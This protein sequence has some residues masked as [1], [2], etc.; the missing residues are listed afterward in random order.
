MSQKRSAAWALA[1]LLGAAVLEIRTMASMRSALPGVKCDDYI[2]RI[3]MLAEINHQFSPALGLSDE[4]L[5][6]DTAVRALEWQWQVASAEARA[7]ITAVLGR[8]GSSVAEFIDVERIEREMA[9]MQ[10]EKP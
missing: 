9:R 2:G 8:D 6:E 5:R 3:G 1:T 7:W 4:R 10:N